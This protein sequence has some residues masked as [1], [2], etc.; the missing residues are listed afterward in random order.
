MQFTMVKKFFIK[1]YL[2][3]SLKESAPH[4]V[5]KNISFEKARNIL[6]LYTCETEEDFNAAGKVINWLNQS[7]K[8]CQSVGCFSTRKRPAFAIDTINS[9][10]LSPAEHTSR[11]IP[12]ASWLGDVLS[13]EI[14]VLMDL[15]FGRSESLLYIAMHS[16]A[17]FKTGAQIGKFQQVFDLTIQ[18]DT[19]DVQILSEE[20]ARYMDMFNNN[21][22]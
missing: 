4:R 18:C 6:V 14:D 12:N 11:G 5:V 17:G 15:S 22:L 13:G 19:F 21:N 7:G 20:I 9:H 8:K 10:F 3:K 1:R 2:G 16:G